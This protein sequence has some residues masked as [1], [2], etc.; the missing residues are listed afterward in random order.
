V[1]IVN[2]ICGAY[3]SVFDTLVMA[4]STVSAFQAKALEKLGPVAPHYARWQSQRHVWE[5]WNGE[6]FVRFDKTPDI[7]LENLGIMSGQL[8]LLE[9]RVRLS[10]H[11]TTLC[12]KVEIRG[13][14]PCVA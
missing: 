9:D 1:H 13:Q 8:I 14:T 2:E 11:T 6:D 12:V 3:S 7:P 4:Q 10:Q 5:Y